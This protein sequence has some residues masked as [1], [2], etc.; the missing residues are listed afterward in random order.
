MVST[1]TNSFDQSKPIS[2][3]TTT[4][5]KTTSN[6]CDLNTNNNE[7]QNIL[8]DPNLLLSN[9]KFQLLQQQQLQH[10][11]RSIQVDIASSELANSTYSMNLDELLS[12]FETQDRLFRCQFCGI[13]FMERGMYFLHIA[14]HGNNPW[15]CS[16]CHKIMQDKNEFTLHFVNQQ[17]TN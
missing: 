17:H 8:F 10:Q 14:L 9:Q 3:S 16:I 5:T 13:I 6:H 7:T 12:R 11:D 2:Q 15:E 4:L 1:T